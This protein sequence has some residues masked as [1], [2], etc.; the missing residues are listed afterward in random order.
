MI[1][2]T[3][4]GTAV[5]LAVLGFLTGPSAAATFRDIGAACFV[6]DRQTDGDAAG[7]RSCMAAAAMELTGSGICGGQVL[8]TSSSVAYFAALKR[9]RAAHQN[10]CTRTKASVPVPYLLS[11]LAE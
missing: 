11:R 9:G 7:P 4:A 10:I 5:T 6:K 2:R 3:I 1:I 8:R